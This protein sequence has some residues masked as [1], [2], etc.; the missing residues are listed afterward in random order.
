MAASAAVT[1]STAKEYTPLKIQKIQ[2]GCTLTPDV[3]DAE[4]PE[5]FS[6]MLKEG[7]TSIR[8]QALM[9]EMLQPDEEDM[10]N[11]IQVLVSEEMP[12]TSR[13]WILG[14]TA[15]RRILPATVESRHSW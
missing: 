13:T 5:I 4:L 10:F 12:R 11:A 6:R 2:A 1:A 9:R 7:R 8:T 15:T 14:T 3:Y